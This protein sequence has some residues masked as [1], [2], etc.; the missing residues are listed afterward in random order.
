MYRS[1]TYLA[2]L[3]LL[4]GAVAAQP[5]DLGAVFRYAAESGERFWQQTENPPPGM[6]SRALFT[7]ALAL[8]EAGVHPERLERLFGLA[9][10]MQ[11]RDPGSRGY[12]NF[13]WRWSEAEVLDF[14]AVDFC[15][16]SG[17][18]LCL[19]HRDTIPE[20]A[21]GMLQELLEFGTE[22][23]L[24][25]KVPESYTNIA[26]MN[27]VDLVLLGEALG[28][29]EAADEGYRRL[30]R[31]CL[32]TW[33]CGIHEYD[34]PT[35]YGVD[36]D[37]LGFLEAFCERERG[38]K[39]AQA[40]L[41]LFWTDIA[42]NWFPGAERL[43]GA[44]S[45][46]Y[47][48]VA[49]LGY[50]YNQMWWNGWLPGD[51]RG[52]I[53]AVYPALARWRPPDRLRRLNTTRLPRYVRQCWGLSV[54][55]SRTHYL[56]PEVTLS[57]AGARY[58]NMDIPLSVDLAG[59]RTDPRC[60]FIADGRDDPYG[61][62][63]IAAGNH[64]KTLHLTPLWVGAQDY[65]DAV[66]LALYRNRD[67]P[68]GTAS[69]QSHFVMPRKVDAIWVGAQPVVLRKGTPATYPVKPGEAVILRRG[70]AAVGI[71]VPWARDVN[72]NE[73][74]VALVDDGNDYDVIRLTVS[75][76]ARGAEDMAA[77][78]GAALW[79]R[80]TGGLTSDQAFAQWTRSFTTALA[81][82]QAT[83]ER[84][85]VR[86]Q[87]PNS[88][89]A[90]GSDAPFDTPSLIQP[91]PSRAI[92]ELDGEDIGRKLLADIEPIREAAGR[93]EV[94]KAIGV[95]TDR[96]VTFEAEWGVV[97]PPMEVNYDE[98]ASG[99]KYVW[100]PGLPGEG[101]GSALGSV[102]WELRVPQE[103]EYLLWGRVLAPTPNDDSFYVRVFTDAKEV[104]PLT[105][106]QTGVH[107]DWAW[108][109][110]QLGDARQPIPLKLPAG[111]VFLQLR[112]RED[113]TKIDRLF[114]TPNG[115]ERPE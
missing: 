58:S 25:H 105:A 46:D 62:K 42:L 47:D 112:V 5:A 70:T 44:H 108:V 63:T 60:Y 79:V 48:Y 17:S 45:R 89:I 78:A 50:L 88:I 28:K 7:Y 74:A 41:E 100:M 1:A 73:A 75:H 103:G 52:G 10:Q 67:V 43:G 85:A 104:L 94:G 55:E 26:L 102:T 9:K 30:D 22:G 90:V 99:G 2:A 37:S 107:E 15:M 83:A 93:T 38:R 109:K 64:D 81:R 113:G 72:G 95:P 68:P 71:R 65:R 54:S 97:L 18:L 96:G 84:V 51:L 49:G 115:D 27:A 33:E 57:V 76:G 36:L 21:R 77:M 61:K 31:F 98:Q 4:C 91:A 86:V 32:Y 40:L 29:A 11:D 53:G 106:W 80:V 56:M 92:L 82:V 66:G 8:C 69:L 110:V 16:Q 39:Q 87:A 12:G 35:Y 3:G 111:E 19:R 101:G 114:I 14:N 6:D 23:C 13:R 34:S 59:P 24:R 20:P